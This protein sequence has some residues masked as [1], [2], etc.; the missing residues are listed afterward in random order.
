M[1]GT[2]HLNV[3]YDIL[4][5]LHFIRDAERIY[6]FMLEN[7]AKALDAEAASLF[8]SD[9][10]REN[11]ILHSCI[12][13]KG[14]MLELIAEE[15]PFPVG[16]G[17]CGWVA[18]QNQ[19]I[20]VD[21]ASKDQRFNGQVDTLTGFKTKSILCAPV[22][23]GDEVL[24]VIE[25]MNKKSAVFNKNDLDLVAMIGKQTAIALDNARLYNELNSAKNFNESVLMNLSSGFIAV[26]P[27]ERVTHVNP[28][29]RRILNLPESGSI[30]QSCSVVLMDCA[31]LYQQIAKTL[32]SKESV[33][34]Q[35]L[36]FQRSDGSG[37]PIG[38]STFVIQETKKLLGA[39]VVFQ[40]LS[41]FKKD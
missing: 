29:A 31:A 36:Q 19:P 10:A 37:I 32:R 7:L 6:R 39:G 12:G 18:K 11:L 15:L 14:Q 3:L 1:L 27:K 35:E 26:D 23:H 5:D 38:Y 34:R 22:S 33:S 21:D 9:E 8:V 40:D 4:K 41:R 24:G 25:V 13:P 16:R 2:Y 17:I 28:A 20:I 30:G